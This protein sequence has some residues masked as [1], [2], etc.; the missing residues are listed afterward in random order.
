[1]NNWK[2]G[3]RI[4]AGFAAV[5]IIAAALGLYAYAKLGIIENNAKE[6]ASKSLP[7]IYLV[8]QIQTNVEAA[9][10]LLVQNAATSDK[11]EKTALDA[12]IQTI[13]SANAGLVDEYQKLISS[14]KGRELHEVFKSARAAYWSSAD[15][16]LTASR[17]GTT[18]GD[19]RAIEMVRTQLRPL[20]K[21]YAEAA[22]NIVSFNKAGADEAGE[23]IQSSVANAQ[24]G[25]LIGIDKLVKAHLKRYPD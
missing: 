4:G 3:T 16:I 23:T 6:V 25:V 17:A 22:G 24:L 2:I 15:E 21:K 10:S 18:E 8:G 19:R 11:P 14:A 1:M 20:M 5:I 9:Y 12:E 13:R 7:K